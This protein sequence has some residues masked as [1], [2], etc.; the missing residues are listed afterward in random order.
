MKSVFP[1]MMLV[2]A[3][4]E[5]ARAQPA[6]EAPLPTAEQLRVYLT[7]RPEQDVIRWKDA[8]RGAPLAVRILEV[9]EKGVSLQKT[10]PSGVVSRVIPLTE[11]AGLSFHQTDLERRLIHRSGSDSAPL[12]RVLWSV[13]AA[14]LGM[15]GSQVADVGLA[16]ARALRLSKDP[17]AWDEA[18][19]VLDRIESKEPAAHRKEAARIERQ[20]LVLTRALAG[21]D[22][23]DADKLAWQAT[24]RDDNPDA[25]LMAVAWLAD[26]HFDE[27]KKLEENHPRWMEDDEV[28]PLRL[29]FHHLALDFALYPSLFLG[30]RVEE[31]AAGLKK[32]WQV[33]QHTGEQERALHVLEDLA[34]LYPESAAARETAA[35]LARLQSRKQAGV[36]EQS[37][38]APKKDSDEEEAAE[39][40]Q[41]ELPPPPPK[42]YNL[43]DD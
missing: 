18:V 38:D 25:M 23:A 2:A 43:F 30:A 13:R 16:L 29:R 33:Y 35:E 1:A 28:R 17:S 5:P 42:R 4:L 10:V 11:L 14:S 39:D 22:P 40:T 41:A 31:S 15:D 20:S 26:R 3:L 8:A 9:D 19:S 24:E 12:L 21:G 32:A 36:L 27:L 34:A 37:E 7:K 6:A